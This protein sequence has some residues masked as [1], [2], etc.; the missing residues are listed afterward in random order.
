MLKYDLRIATFLPAL[1]MMCVIFH[2]S[3]EEAEASTRT[4]T[5]VGRM[6]VMTVADLSHREYT[7]E[8]LTQR[9]IAVDGA[10]RKTAHMAEYACLAAFISVPLLLYGMRGKKLLF[11]TIFLPLLYAASDEYHQTFVKGRSGNIRDVLID[12]I[13]IIIYVIFLW[14]LSRKR[15]FTE[16]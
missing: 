5:A 3:A 1:I 9:A 12:G 16:N 14:K 4:S 2:F 11:L 8:E 10:V 6:I 13:G 7:E 15:D